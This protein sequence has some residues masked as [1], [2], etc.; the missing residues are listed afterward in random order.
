MEPNEIA[1]ALSAPLI[2]GQEAK[3]TAFS[4]AVDRQQLVIHALQIEQ[5]RAA[6]LHGPESAGAQRIQ[7]MLNIHGRSFAATQAESARAQAR[8]PQPNP[9]E[10][11]IYGYVTN[12]AGAPVSGVE[13]SAVDEKGVTVR[14]ASAE[15]TGAFAIHITRPGTRTSA[16]AKSKAG[17]GAAKSKTGA[18]ASRQ[19]IT[20]LHL[21]A[22]DKKQTFQTEGTVTFQFELGKLGYEDLVVPS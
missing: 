17:A 10:F 1:N 5:R 2:N 3:S 22:R 4:H 16:A 14:T 11:I 20:T 9:Q 7:A 12:K 6:A 15:D 8:T 18:E 21:V 13:V 19:T